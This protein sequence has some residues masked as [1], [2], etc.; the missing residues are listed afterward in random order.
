MTYDGRLD[1]QPSNGGEEVIGDLPDLLVGEDLRI[2]V[3][4]VDGL[5]VAGPAGREGGIAALL[6][7]LPPAVPTAGEEP[8]A[9]HEHDR[10]PPRGVR[11]ID[12]LLL[13]GGKG[14]QV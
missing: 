12:V 6:E 9:V 8:E 7:E 11:A 10:L 13:V 2:C 1:R 14:L 5:G 3:R 4:L